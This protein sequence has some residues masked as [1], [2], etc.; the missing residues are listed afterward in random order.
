MTIRTAAGEPGGARGAA[1][2][3]G[4]R[5]RARRA[6]GHAGR[7]LLGLVFLLAGV[8]KALD[9]DEFARQM[10][11][12]G[13]LP[14][15]AA[16]AAAPI[17]IGLE[18]VLGACL[19]A[20]AWPTAAAAAGGALLVLFVL[21]EA[22]GLA[23]GR[24]EA[25]G[26]F[27]AYVQRTPGQVIIED[28]VFL[29]FAALASWGL[30]GWRGLRARRAALTAGLS[31]AL[32]FG[33]VFAS[34]S[35][36]L[37]PIVTRLAPGRSL[38]DLGLGAA[39]PRLAE[40]RHL[41]ALL[42]VT[43]PGAAKWAAGLNDLADDPRLPPILGL[44]PAGEEAIAAFLWSAAPAFDIRPVDRTVLK[45]LYRRLPRCFLLQDGTVVSVHDGAPPRAADLLSSE[46]P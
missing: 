40:G 43:D 37:D 45:P 39:L 15:G 2:A 31:A 3:A 30:R 9:P 17:L 13:L 35:L 28:L 23:Q 14:A 5:G 36:P 10:G 1:P 18:I 44:T 6:V 32:G 19:L 8:L 29:G 16:A 12:Y 24:T 11:G 20:G 25:C 7:I 21:V 33:F 22:Y 34:P 4:G 27:G 42:D 41:V 26:C 46:A 38:G